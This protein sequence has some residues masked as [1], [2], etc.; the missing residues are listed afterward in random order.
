MLRNARICITHV[1]T[2]NAN[3]VT[4][5]EEGSNILLFL[6]SVN[7]KNKYRAGFSF[8]RCRYFFMLTEWKV[9]Y[10]IYIIHYFF[11]EFILRLFK[12]L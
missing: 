7:I 1:K 2:V 3:V 12:C 11:Q 9:L 10:A 8:T 5:A 4:H 6:T